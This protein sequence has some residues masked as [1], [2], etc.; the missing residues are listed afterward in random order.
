[1]VQMPANDETKRLPTFE[2]SLQQKL[3]MLKETIR[4]VLE[5]I[6]DHVENGECVTRYTKERHNKTFLIAATRQNLNCRY[7]R[8][9][10]TTNQQR[11]FFGQHAFFTT[12]CDG[13]FGSPMLADSVDSSGYPFEDFRHFWNVRTNEAIRRNKS[14]HITP[15]MFFRDAH[16]SDEGLHLLFWDSFLYGTR[17]THVFRGKRFTQTL[18]QTEHATQYYLSRTQLLIYRDKTIFVQEISTQCWGSHRLR[19]C[20]QPVSTT[21]SQQTTS[22]KPGFILIFRL[23]FYNSV[24]KKLSHHLNIRRP[25]ICSTQRIH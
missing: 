14:L 10:S 19:F 21:K 1:M 11:V 3:Y 23:P 9:V 4:G 2:R 25:C 17:S 6:S 13:F 22:A 5:E 24:L 12:K 16:I 18:P 7:H 8:L 20:K 15:L